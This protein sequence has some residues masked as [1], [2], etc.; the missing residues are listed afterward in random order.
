MDDHII[1][2]GDGG[3]WRMTID[4]KELAAS[5]GVQKNLVGANGIKFTEKVVSVPLPRAKKLVDLI[6]RYA[7]MEEARKLDT[8]LIP[9]TKLYRYW[10]D[11]YAGNYL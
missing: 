4:L 8:Y 1:R 9:N 7:P 6:A 3:R 5:A 2:F 11:K 10:R